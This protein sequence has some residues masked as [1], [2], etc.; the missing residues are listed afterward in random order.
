MAGLKA[1][2]ALVVLVL[3]PVSAPV[4]ALEPMPVPVSVPVAGGPGDLVGC[5]SSSGTVSER[6]ACG[7][8]RGTVSVSMDREKRINGSTSAGRKKGERKRE[9]AG[10]S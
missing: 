1:A 3:V 10:A 5:G 9:R 6:R 8:E 4:S 2:V 7:G